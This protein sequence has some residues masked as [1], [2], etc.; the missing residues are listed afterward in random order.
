MPS[1]QGEQMS[2]RAEPPEKR[3]LVIVVDDDGAVCN[4][5][6]FSLEVEGF[7]VRTY[8]SVGEL[9]SDPDPETSSCLV[10]DLNLPGMSGLEAIAVLRARRVLVPAILITTH[11]SPAVR[12]R[13]ARAAVPIVEK[14]FLG[15]ALLDQIRIAL[16]HCRH[17]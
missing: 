13:A 3:P 9:L 4:S 6:K 17:D 16:E 12:E 15:N 10:V 14:P 11:P 8:S 2:P 7:A 1:V 5:L